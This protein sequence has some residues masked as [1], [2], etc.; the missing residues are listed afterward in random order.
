MSGATQFVQISAAEL[1]THRKLNAIFDG[2]WNDPVVG[3][4]VR[5][6]AKEKNPEIT[7]PDESPIALAA[8]K[9]VA[10][11]TTQVTGLSTALAEFQAKA[12]QKEGE[13]ALRKQLGDVQAKYGLTDDGMAKVIETMQQRQ[14]ADPEAAAL[15]FRE[16]IP[17][18]PPVSATSRHFDTKADMFGTTRKDDA[19]EQLHTNPDAFFADV[20][21][22]VFS[23]IPA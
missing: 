13:T 10:D 5:L 9:Q 15:L 4:Q 8:K 23:E 3:E 14:L 16:S 21:N 11:L 12:A 6:R 1:E 20:V 22:Q 7:I 18:A 17:K 2:L 19:W